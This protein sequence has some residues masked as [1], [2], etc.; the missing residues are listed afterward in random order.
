M[1]TM[2][3]QEVLND[4]YSR[5][6]FLSRLAVLVEEMKLRSKPNHYREMRPFDEDNVLKLAIKSLTLNY[7]E[8]LMIG[9]L[10][11]EYLKT[12]LLESVA[13]E[14][15]IVEELLV[16]DRSIHSFIESLNY[17]EIY[18]G[19]W[20][21]PVMG[22]QVYDKR[23]PEDLPKAECLLPIFEAREKV[24]KLFEE[25]CDMKVRRNE[26]DIEDLFEARLTDY[27]TPRQYEAV[28]EYQAL[29]KSKPKEAAD[30]AFMKE[31]E[32]DSI[33]KMYKSCKGVVVKFFNS[34]KS[35]KI[36]EEDIPILLEYV[37]RK[38]IVDTY[39][40]REYEGGNARCV[41]KQGSSGVVQ[42][43]PAFSQYVLDPTE[44]TYT[45]QFLHEK[46]DN[47][48]KPD[49]IACNLKALILDSV[50]YDDI[51]LEE[52]NK[53]FKRVDELFNKSNFS[54]LMGAGKLYSANAMRTIAEAHRKYINEHKSE[55]FD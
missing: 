33:V 22:Y 1:N 47:A 38:R 8:I 46:I 29:R 45:I 35:R 2:A 25:V 18:K 52:L 15:H 19:Q 31:V 37:M 32:N 11:K 40:E 20:S 28:A 9:R 6:D 7:E 54:K 21:E 55:H 51:P 3:T 44:A 50:L 17:Y 53:E 14:E 16:V 13:D 27:S 12:H 26:Q 49:I 5:G 34:I 23:A 4:Q 36:V 24:V 41:S 48:T 10:Y 43:M 30:M 39:L 42:T